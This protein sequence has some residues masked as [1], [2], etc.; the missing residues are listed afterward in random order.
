MFETQ[1]SQSQTTSI[2]EVFA[3][4]GRRREI[5]KVSLRVKQDQSIFG[6]RLF[7]GQGVKIIEVGDRKQTRRSGVWK[8]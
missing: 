6:I 5:R 4:G 8:T 7:D 2:Q 3:L 1:H